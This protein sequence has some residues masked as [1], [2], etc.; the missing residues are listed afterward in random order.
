MYV[1]GGNNWYQEH[2]LGQD[3]KRH[4]QAINTHGE[5]NADSADPLGFVVQQKA[6]SSGVHTIC[7]NKM[8]EPK[9]AGLDSGS[10]NHK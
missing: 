9:N 2:N 10:S 1:E 5:I 4:A 3:Q 6:V 7:T 8:E